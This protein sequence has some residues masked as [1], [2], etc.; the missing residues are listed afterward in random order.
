M[1]P[2]RWLSKVFTDGRVGSIFNAVPRAEAERMQDRAFSCSFIRRHPLGTARDEMDQEGGKDLF[3]W[4]IKVHN[5]QLQ[6]LVA[7]TGTE[8][9]G[10]V[11]PTLGLPG[12]PSSTRK[13]PHSSIQLHWRSGWLLPRLGRS[14]H[15]FAS[16]PASHFGRPSGALF[17]VSR[18][19]GKEGSSLVSQWMSAATSTQGKQAQ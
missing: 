19:A 12:I 3:A 6:R 16:P 14:S 18:S 11:L 1:V 5:K 8:L 10:L 13:T 9:P 7:G 17:H 2:V 15:P 4:Y